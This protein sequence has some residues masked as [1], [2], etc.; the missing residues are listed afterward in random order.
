MSNLAIGFFS[1][2]VRLAPKQVK[3]M[4]ANVV[5]D[6]E[7]WAEGDTAF[8]RLQAATPLGP[9]GGILTT[10]LSTAHRMIEA[11]ERHAII[12]RASRAIEH[13][14]GHRPLLCG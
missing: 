7:A 12:P 13:F 4:V 2:P 3:I 8:L 5:V 11:A 6:A 10:D 1:P 9:I 14:T